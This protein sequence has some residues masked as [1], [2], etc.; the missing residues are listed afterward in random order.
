M[1]DAE[2]RLFLA[3]W[4]MHFGTDSVTWPTRSACAWYHDEIPHDWVAL[5]PPLLQY[6]NYD[7]E[8][9]PAQLNEKGLA[10]LKGDT[11]GQPND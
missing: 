2:I 7:D 11:D 3:G 9:G 10:F 5:D 6:F 8:D 4:L 1:T